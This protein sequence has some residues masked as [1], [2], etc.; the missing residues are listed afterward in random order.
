MIRY[1]L[2][3]TAGHGFDSWFRSAAA[4]DAL[5]AAGELACPECGER[6]VRKAPMAPG[7]GHGAGGEHPLARLRRRVE[8]EAEHVG[9]RF[10]EE[11]RAIHRGEA[12]DRPIWGEAAPA[13]ARA[14]RDEGLPVA[15]LPF[16][17]RSKLQ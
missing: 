4:F 14:L 16:R 15:P 8:S 6:R 12:P 7:V 2:R 11:A 1:D 13:E 3:C 17:P 10:A 9:A 5:A